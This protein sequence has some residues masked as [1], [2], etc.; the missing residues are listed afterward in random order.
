MDQVYVLISNTCV[1]Q[2]LALTYFVCFI[3]HKNYSRID[4]PGNLKNLIQEVDAIRDL[5]VL[6][7]GL[8]VGNKL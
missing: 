5:M 1:F 7:W 4:N 6:L 2:F 3:D 8:I